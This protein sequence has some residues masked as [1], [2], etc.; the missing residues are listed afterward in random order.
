MCDYEDSQP[1]CAMDI[2]KPGNDVISLVEFEL[3]ILQ[4]CPAEMCGFVKK[5][6][7][8]FFPKFRSGVSA[9]EEWAVSLLI[10][11]CTVLEY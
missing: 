7:S 1:R 8:G 6:K 9:T 3:V 10:N 5:K 4:A 2:N 11:T